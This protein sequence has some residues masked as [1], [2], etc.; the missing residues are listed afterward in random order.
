MNRLIIIV[1]LSF[2]CV[3]SYAQK[4]KSFV[5]K[6]NKQYEQQ[7]YPD[8]EVNYR[9]ALEQQPN[10]E[11]ATFNLGNALFREEKLQEA[12]EQFL[13]AADAGKNKTNIAMAYHNLGNSYLMDK[14]YQESI[15]A[16]KKALRNNPK[17]VETKY[18]LAFAQRMLKNPPKNQNQNN[19]NKNDK[20]QQNK[21]KKDDKNK[22][23]KD[24]KDKNNK[25]KQK[26]DQN[27][28]N[29]NDKNNKDQQQQQPQTGKI[30]KDD[31]KRMLQAIQNDEKNTQDKLKKEKA[32]AKKVKPDVDW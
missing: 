2:V 21:D 11:I 9:K 3:G 1:L 25:D 24:N 16:Y 27:K 19:Q 26:Q 4:E 30:S 12:G 32:Q 23:N 5:R 15:D 8:A 13:K 17:D 14:K 20:N 10:S 22:D 29:K 31:A 28:D 7:K 6:G 18:N